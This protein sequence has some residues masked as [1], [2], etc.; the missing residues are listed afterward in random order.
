MGISA[1]TTIVTRSIH[2]FPGRQVGLSDSGGT[3]GWKGEP[4]TQ[5]TGFPVK[6]E[7]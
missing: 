1:E 2:S 7:S 3:L 4:T 6:L 5:K